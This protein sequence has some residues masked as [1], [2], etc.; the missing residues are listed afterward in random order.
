MHPGA[1]HRGQ[2]ILFGPTPPLPSTPCVLGDVHR[3][4]PIPTTS[5][6]VV[7]SL[8]VAPG[9]TTRWRATMVLP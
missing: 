8:C 2:R 7:E 1:N 5:G 3:R 4:E 9:T 6:E